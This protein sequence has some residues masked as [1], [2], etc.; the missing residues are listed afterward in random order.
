MKHLMAK[1]LRGSESDELV[2]AVASHVLNCLLAPK[3]FI[4]KLNSGQIKNEPVTIKNVADFNIIKEQD[5]DDEFALPDKSGP[6]V[7]EPGVD[8]Q[9]KP[10]ISKREKKKQKRAAKKGSECF[11][12]DEQDGQTKRVQSLNDLLFSGGLEPVEFD[13]LD[14]FNELDIA[15]NVCESNIPES[16]MLTPAKL[17]AQIKDLAKQRYRYTVLPDDLSQLRCL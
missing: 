4:D 6:L 9:V 8:E 13:A 10:T 14:I 7:G 5:S 15:M 11:N 12:N 2:S 3:E 16:L 17:Y 1:Y